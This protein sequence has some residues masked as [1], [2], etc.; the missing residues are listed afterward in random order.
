MLLYVLKRL[1]WFVPLFFLISMIAFG[2]S[3]M[4]PGDPVEVH[5]SQSTKVDPTF[6]QLKAA[7][8][9]DQRVLEEF[10]LHKPPFYFS[11][12][13][14]AQSDTLY[15]IARKNRRA[16]LQQL[17]AK[18]GNW[19]RVQNYYHQIEG[20]EIALTRLPDTLFQNG[21]TLVTKSQIGRFKNALLQLYL[22]HEDKR[23]EREI[24]RIQELDILSEQAAEISFAYQNLKEQATPARQYIP[25]FHWHGFDNQYHNWISGFLSGD[26]GISRKDYKPVTQKISEALSWT[27]T[28][29]S[30]AIL[31]AYGL[32]IWLGVL[33]ARKKG[34]KTDR[35]ISL[36]L[37]MLY[38]LP[39]FWIAILLIVF[40]T[41]PEYGAWTDIF[42]STGTGSLPDSAPFWSRFWETASHLVLP[43]FCITYGSLAFI[44]RQMRSAMIEV[45]PQR[46]IQTARAKGLPENKVIWKHAFRNALFPLI[47]I[48]ASVLPAALTGSVI[49]EHI[50]NI[51]GMGK[52]MLTSI[53]AEDWV[54]VYA[55]LLLGA[56][57]TMIGLLLADLLYAWADPRVRLR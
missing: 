10:G 14:A 25:A 44:A 48:F 45:L 6:V 51:P 21:D 42:P 19:E 17:S 5:G 29:N 27:L 43:I 26:F 50:F 22:Q 28:M 31:L 37:F 13:T 53:F 32:A 56:V 2:L 30:V 23:I 52:L 18:Y 4:T 55:I 46:Y 33:S 57:L 41:T 7:K 38:S 34:S 12:T 35:G 8:R 3:R 11:L 49:I 36:G 16:T 47:T 20:A 54:V 9:A 40:F 39:N 24:S 1:A 15:R